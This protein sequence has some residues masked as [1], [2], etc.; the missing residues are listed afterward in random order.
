MVNN[1]V[2]NSNMV[3][4]NVKKFDGYEADLLVTDGAHDLLCYYDTYPPIHNIDIGK[5]ISKLSSLYACN[6]VRAELCQPLIQKGDDVYSYFL[7]GQVI[8]TNPLPV[9]KI[10]DL[11]VEVDT[12]LPKDISVGEFVEFRV[13]RLDASF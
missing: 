7:R 11:F 8:R 13:Q 3:V 12:Q 4:R 9:I 2:Y 10:Y 1:V 6:V 5:K